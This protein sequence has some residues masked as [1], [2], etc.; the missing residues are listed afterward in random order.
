V[1]GI[2]GIEGVKGIEGRG[3]GLKKLVFFMLYY[4]V[5]CINNTNHKKLTIY[6]NH[7]PGPHR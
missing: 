3:E 4:S 5:I 2:M 1:N 7:D 6:K